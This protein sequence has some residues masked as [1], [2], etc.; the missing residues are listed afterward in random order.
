MEGENNRWAVLISTVINMA[1]KAAKQ[2]VSPSEIFQKVHPEA[3]D[4]E[5]EA[6]KESGKTHIRIPIEQY[7][8]LKRGR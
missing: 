6:L 1:G 3:N 5:I 2:N 8:E 4:P 7:T